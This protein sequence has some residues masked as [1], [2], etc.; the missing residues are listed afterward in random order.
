M[1]EAKKRFRQQRG[2]DQAWCALSPHI[3]GMNSLAQNVLPSNTD[4]VI[5]TFNNITKQYDDAMYTDLPQ[6]WPRSFKWKTADDEESGSI[7]V[8]TALQVGNMLWFEHYSAGVA[9]RSLVTYMEEAKNFS[10]S[11][12][13]PTKPSAPYPRMFWVT[14][15]VGPVLFTPRGLFFLAYV[16][17]M[18]KNAPDTIQS[19]HQYPSS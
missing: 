2:A 9:S 7:F 15:F 13:E 6:W 12:V 5:T 16:V 19:S 18:Q 1:E 11:N 4:D 8:S 10:G 17:I 3:L 14:Y